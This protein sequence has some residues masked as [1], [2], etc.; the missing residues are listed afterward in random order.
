MKYLSFCLL[1]LMVAGAGAQIATGDILVNRKTA[2][3]MTQYQVAPDVRDLLLSANA[4]AMLAEL[5][6]TVDPLVQLGN[7][8][9]GNG[10]VRLFDGANDEFLGLRVSDGEW[11]VEGALNASG[12]IIA[13]GLSASGTV[14]SGGVSSARTG[15]LFDALTGGDV[16][17]S[18]TN[19]HSGTHT[20]TWTTQGNAAVTV[21]AG[22]LTISGINVAETLGGEK[23]F[24]ASSTQAG[25]RLG[26]LAGDPSSGLANGSTWYNSTLHAPRTRINGTTRSLLHSGSSLADLATRNAAD[27]TGTLGAAQLPLPGTGSL[28]GVMRNGGAVGQFVNGINASGQLTFATPAVGL[29]P[30]GDGS[31]LTGITAAQVGALAPDG[32]GSMLTGITAAQVGALAPDGDGSGLTGITTFSEATFTSGIIKSGQPF[33][34]YRHYDTVDSSAVPLIAVSLYDDQDPPVA[35]GHSLFGFRADGAGGGKQIFQGSTNTFEFEGVGAANTAVVKAFQ[36]VGDGSQLT[37]VPVPS[38]G[39]SG[40][41]LQCRQGSGFGPVSNSSVSGRAITLG[42]AEA[43]GVV[44]SGLL[45]VRNTSAATNGNQQVSPSIVREGRGFATTDGVSQVVRFRDHVLPVQGAANPSATWRLQSEINNSNVWV[46]AVTYETAANTL[47]IGPTGAANPSIVLNGP[48]GAAQITAGTNGLVANQN[49]Q[50]TDTTYRSAAN[51]GVV[52]FLAMTWGGLTQFALNTDGS[53][54]NLLHLRNGTAAQQMRIANTW[55]SLT[56]NETF[57]IDWRT[58]ANICRVGTEKGS[59]G[60]TARAMQ[61]MTDGTARVTLGASGEVIQSSL[62][63]PASATAPGVQGEVRYDADFI[64]RCVAPNSWKRAP[65]SAW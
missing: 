22:T 30:D 32:D 13:T 3:G 37:G 52:R 40:S 27:L 29:A 42:A 25:L 10:E 48:V 62:P 28:G 15:F 39:G 6:V 57:T 5:G 24:T 16:Q 54:L 20:V 11:Y 14:A 33:L 44:S 49:F 47:T 23:T 2:G 65:L 8:G 53:E 19:G 60:G 45:T 59:G 56:N 50:L 64:Y 43:L 35:I 12:L 63:A 26:S 18:A 34:D 36:F 38:P 41:E 51:A 58:T 55:T 21:P 61:L 46:N 17:F 9:S 1:F 7:D 4:A 31:M